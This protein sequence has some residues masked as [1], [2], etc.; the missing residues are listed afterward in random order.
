M[1]QQAAEERLQGSGCSKEIKAHCKDA[2]SQLHCL[3]KY[4]AEISAGCKADVGKSVPFLCSEA[5]DEYCDVLMGGILPCLSNQI[6]NLQGPCKDAVWATKKVSKQVNSQKS[7]TLAPAA[8]K[9][10]AAPKV[11]ASLS[12]REAHLDAKLIGLSQTSNKK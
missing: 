8:S 11:K 12:A 1:A 10:A 3:G 4:P 5:I 2:Q 6:K 7:P 9:T